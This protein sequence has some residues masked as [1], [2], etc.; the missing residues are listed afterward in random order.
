MW[1]ARY[2]IT[3][4]KM[5][6]RLLQG[7]A[8]LAVVA[9]QNAERYEKAEKEAERFKLLYQAGQELSKITDLE[10]IEQAYEVVVQIA[11]TQSQSQ[12]F[13]YRYDEEIENAEFTLRFSSPD[14]HAPL[15]TTI[16][17]N[18][19]MNGHVA[20]TRTKLLIND[21]HNLPPDIPAIKL[22]DPQIRSFLIIPILFNDQ[23]YGNLGL[24]HEEVGHFRGTD[25]LF[26]EWLAQELAS[27]IHRLETVKARQEFEQRAQAEEEMSSIGQSAFEVT[28]RLGNDLGLVEL[29]IAD[30]RTE[31]EQTV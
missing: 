2:R 30:I 24:R 29:Y 3:S 28:H 20:R 1:K 13:I 9:L 14:R 6:R 26:F 17:V 7:L 18:E 31:L 27:T 10:Q 22:S 5:T 8:A 21:T 15:F 4:M 19:G 23:Y 16:G 25:I 11:D 12:V